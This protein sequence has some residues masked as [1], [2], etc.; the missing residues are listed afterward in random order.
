MLRLSIML[1]CF[2]LI[3]T[4][5]QAA[6]NKRQL[7][8]EDIMKKAQKL[9]KKMVTIDTHVDLKIDLATPK[10]NPGVRLDSQKVDLVKMS[11]GGL[12]AVFFAVWVAQEELSKESFCKAYDLAMAK[13]AAIH[14]MCAAYNADKVEL[15]LSPDDV[16]RIKKAGKR[17]ALIGVENGFSIGEDIENLRYFYDLGARYVTITHM[18]CNQLA[19]SSD[20]LKDIPASKHG[21]LSDFGK[22]VIREMNRLG[23]MIDISHSGPKTVSDILALSKAPVIASHSGCRALCDVNRNLT[24]EQM[25]AIKD[26]GGTVQIVA[27]ADF[28]KKPGKEADLKVFVDHIDYAVHLIGIDHVGIG[29]DFDGGGGIPGFEDPSDC[30]NV[31][32]E[33][34]RR[35]YSDSDIEKIWGG[36]LLRVWRKVIEAAKE[37]NRPELG[38]L[39]VGAPADIAIFNVLNG[40]FTYTDTGG[41]VLY[42][43]RKI[44]CEMTMFGGEVVYDPKGLSKKVL[45]VHDE[46]GPE[47]FSVAQNTPN[48]FNTS[49]II[50]FNLSRAGHTTVEIVNAAG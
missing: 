8:D 41:G 46:K 37:I 17:S 2:A 36:N 7:S 48:P 13:F 44:M 47:P 29:S 14:R 25:L 4:S 20:P 39:S 49:T 35:G 15:A 32:A 10:R 28:L 11:E 1:A 23:M 19:D 26:N 38:N 50:H 31:T 3:A 16:I 42:G 12:D 21:G 18:G 9:H 30:M 33:L 40:N 43:D 27:L 45:S 5:S 34:I 22:E 6:S 24:N